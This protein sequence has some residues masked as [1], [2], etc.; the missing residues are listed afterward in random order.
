[1]TDLTAARRAVKR[2]NMHDEYKQTLLNNLPP[3]YLVTWCRWAGLIKEAPCTR[4]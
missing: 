3:R 1:M 2:A 4:S